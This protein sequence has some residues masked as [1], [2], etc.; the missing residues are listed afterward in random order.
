MNPRWRFV[1]F[2]AVG[3]A[4]IGVQLAALWFLTG[5]AHTH[6]LAATSLAVATAIVH[7]FVWHRRWTWAERTESRGTIAQF[8]RFA[9][10][11]GVVSLAGN[12]VVMVA[13]VPG[14]GVT[15]LVANG[16][17]ITACGVLNF[18]L[19]D[20]VVFRPARPPGPPAPARRSL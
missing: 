11:N 4:G 13:L 8:L 20:S 1:R 9:A 19:G 5:V 6:Y 3:V 18:W 16:I 10:A 14:A 15:P 17:A 7:N 2:N 12:L